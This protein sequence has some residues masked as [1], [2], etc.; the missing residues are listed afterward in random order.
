MAANVRYRSIFYN[1][2][3]TGS[4]DVTWTIEILDTEAVAQVHNF[5]TDGH[6]DESFEGLTTDLRPGVYPSNL[7]FGMYIRS[8]P[9]NDKGTTFGPNESFITDLFAAAEGR[10]LVRYYKGEDL[11][12]VGPIIQDQCSYEDA[13]EPYLLHITAVDGMAKWDSE[14]YVSEVGQI[15]YYSQKGTIF[16]YDTSTLLYDGLITEVIVISHSV[17]QVSVAPAAWGQITT[18]AH[19]QVYSKNSPG[20]GWVFQGEGLWAKELTYTNEVETETVGERYLLTR[21]IDD[22]AHRTVAE[23]IKR[24]IAETRMTDEYPDP[25]IMYDCSCEWYEHSMEDFVS[26]PFTM[27]R[28]HEEP[29]IGGSW[30]NAM[31]EIS[32]LLNLR[33]YYS[34]A[35]YHFEQITLRDATTFT[36][37]I[38]KADGTSAGAA[39]TASLDI[40]FSAVEI[41]P[42]TGGEYK[43]LAPFKSVE[44]TLALDSADLLE[45]VIWKEGSMGMKYLGRI[46]RVAGTQITRI[47]LIQAITS[48]FDPAILATLDPEIVNT[49]CEHEVRVFTQVRLTNVLT[50]TT[51]YL[52]QTVAEFGT[53]ETDEFSWQTNQK[54]GRQ[55]NGTV[56][57]VENY[58]YTKDH[59]R[60]IQ[61]TDNIPDPTDAMYDV[62]VSLTFQVFFT[63]ILGSSFW[64]IAHPD[65]HWHSL[66]S[67]TGVDKPNSMRF[68]SDNDPWTE[69][70]GTVAQGKTYFIENNVSN[71]IKVKIPVQWGDTGQ[72]KKAI[73]IYDGDKWINSVAWSILGVGDPQDILA[74]LVSEIASFRT[75]PRKLYSG[76]FITTMPNAESRILRGSLYY[77]PLSCRKDLD[78][79]AF[80]GQFLQI[81]KTTPP[82]GGTIGEPYPTDQIPVGT[83]G[84][85]FEGEDDAP[86]P[87]DL[88]FETNEVI[89]ATD[90]LTDLDIVNTEGVFVEKNTWVRIIH[91]TTGV[92]EVV[93]LTSDIEPGDTNM[94]F[95]S[96]EFVNSYPDAS[97]IVPVLSVATMPQGLDQYYYFF[98]HN[99]TATFI[100]AVRFNFVNG[101]TTS[102]HDINK[103]YMVMRNHQRIYCNFAPGSDPLIRIQSYYFDWVEKTWNF[104]DDGLV[105]ETILI[106]AW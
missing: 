41:D 51:Y 60:N 38:Y 25:D 46:K 14:D 68:Y 21:D 76:G 78:V 28:V 64:W 79:D 18:F 47:R 50:G 90:T 36:R 22:D 34:N 53:W 80:Q 97:L 10:F 95:S 82:E 63:N 67:L 66:T 23:Y 59:V 88:V 49:Y 33:I 20:T 30:L 16:A 86:D 31:Q 32:K 2:T 83:T 57:S 4:G 39:E 94:Q 35:R 58:G 74:L 81:A 11:Q 37:F 104:Y 77:L 98:K 72:F 69:M 29:L 40:D 100:D 55:A 99:Y 75:A 73:Q 3:N 24:A 54:F 93:T 43:S 71:S 26:D 6:P 17:E 1:T 7:K 44:A 56:Y 85:G 91:P 9:N 92:N 87:I 15:V 13:S 48:T 12:F 45:G 101:D 27:M 84:V 96:H 103:R 102:P 62:H 61:T 52:T 105:D 70:T 65:N 42:E 106:I 89:T 8:V 19:R 5:E